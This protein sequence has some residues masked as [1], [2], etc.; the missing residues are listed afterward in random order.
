[1]NHDVY[2]YPLTIIKDEKTGKYQVMLM[3]IV[4]AEDD[5]LTEQAMRDKVLSTPV[6]FD[7]RRVHLIFF[8]SAKIRSVTVGDLRGLETDWYAGHKP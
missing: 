8:Y 2:R 1:M 4:Q 5:N 7:N 3:G 6:E